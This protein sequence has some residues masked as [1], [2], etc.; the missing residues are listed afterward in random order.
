MNTKYKVGVLISV[1]LWGLSFIFTKVA[2]EYLT[3]LLLVAFRVL[4][5]MTLLLSFSKLTGRLQ[6]LTRRDTLTFGLLACAEPVGYFLLETYG[7]LNV[8]PT[9]AC[10]I[11]STI[12]LLTPVF[13]Y[14]VSG[15]SI[16]WRVGVGLVISLVGVMGVTFADGFEGISGR[17]IGVLFLLGAVLMAMIYTVTVRRLGQRF[18]AFSIVAWQNLFSAMILLPLVFAFEGQRVVELNFAWE[19]VWRVLALGVLC[20]S[21]AF[22]LYAAGLRVLK[23][24]QTVIFINLMPGIT[25]LASFWI[26]DEELGVIKISGI[27]VTILGLYIGL[28]ERGEKNG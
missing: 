17:V 23:V 19:W 1:I 7:V 2:L 3:P 13:A 12:P 6:K 24:A 16:S 20:S 25:A 9:L 4:I 8:S 11:V 15:E 5:A 14:F 21:V 28:N 26:M 27:V 22:V 10:V 18:N